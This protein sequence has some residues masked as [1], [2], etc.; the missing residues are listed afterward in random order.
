MHPQIDGILE[1]S[2][3]V[4]DV[5]RS[6]R[7]YQE[8][9]GFTVIA[10][11]GERGCAMRAGIRQVLLLFKK[12]ASRAIQSPHDGDGELHIAF[13]IPAAELAKLGILAPN[14]RN[15]SRRKAP[16]GIG[17]LEPL[18]QRPRPSFA[19][20]RHSRH[21]VR[22]LTLVFRNPRGC[23]TR[24]LCV[25]ALPPNVRARFQPCRKRPRRNRLQPLRDSPFSFGGRTFRSDIRA[26]LPTLSFR[27]ERP[28][29]FFRPFSGR[30]I[31]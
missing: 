16:V 11:F 20:T 5:P 15:R 9:F 22:L 12:G 7:F 1:S 31:A 13:A 23:P 26:T 18:L 25:W 6:V 17:R 24:R 21:L 2:L 10:D 29:F 8:T 4:S 3:Y 30:R 19:R 27:T 28:G 14:Q